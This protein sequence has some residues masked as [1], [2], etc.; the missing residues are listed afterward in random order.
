MT[1]QKKRLRT[2]KKHYA[3]KLGMPPGTPM[4]IGDED[5]T[6][7]DK[8]KISRLPTTQLS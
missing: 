4:Y 8:P 2:R 1:A 6:K 7:L 5:I 3:K